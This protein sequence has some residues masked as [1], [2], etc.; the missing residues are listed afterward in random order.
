MQ[1]IFGNVM[2][3]A[4]QL[5][6]RHRFKQWKKNHNYRRADTYEHSCASCGWCCRIDHAHGQ[7]RKCKCM[8]W[9]ESEESTVQGAY[10][11]DNHQPAKGGNT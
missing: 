7:A 1:D 6:G 3:P 8:G 2:A 4:N 9:D 5:H 10:V 11:C